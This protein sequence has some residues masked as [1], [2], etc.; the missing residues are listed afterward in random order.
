MRS[1]MRE[2]RGEREKRKGLGRGES[3][4]NGTIEILKKLI[5]R[6]ISNKST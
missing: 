4:M 6:G 2:R 5:K 1:G 3:E